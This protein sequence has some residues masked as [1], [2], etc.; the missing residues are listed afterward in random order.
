LG[1]AYG[2]TDDPIITL[3][4]DPSGATVTRVRAVHITQLREAVN[5]VRHL[6]GLG[7]YTWTNLTLTPNVSPI[8]A[9]DVRD[10]RTAL[11]AA[12]TALG[13]PLPDYIDSTIYNGQNGQRTVVKRDHIR[14][15]REAA[16]RGKGATSGG[17]GTPVPADGLDGLTY[18]ASTNRISTAEWEYDAAG[19]QTRARSA[20]G[21][22][23]RYEY[24]AA[25]R[26][27]RVLTDD[28]SAVLASYTYGE[29]NERLIAEEGGGRTYYVSGGAGVIV[30]Y[31]EATNSTQPQWSR[32]YVYLGARLL[33]GTRL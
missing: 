9:A 26:L 30:E 6:A 5:A 14:Q 11:G 24:D 12:L 25:G 7:D 27:A 4:D 28:R 18:D 17:G 20:S 23:Q 31:A 13:I 15:L 29:S 33:S 22:W 3:T 2:F 10:L 19:N 16:T 32:S 1:T 8:A 21:G